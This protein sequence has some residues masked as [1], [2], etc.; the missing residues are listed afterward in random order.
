[1]KALMWYAILTFIGYCLLESP[2][3]D[4]PLTSFGNFM[5][6][7]GW[8]LFLLPSIALLLLVVNR[9]ANISFRFRD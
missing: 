8:M 2:F 3:Y 1:M 4:H 9:L 5:Q 7:L 6:A